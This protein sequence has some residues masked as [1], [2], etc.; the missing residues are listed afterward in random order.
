MSR[1]FIGC[2]ALLLLIYSAVSALANSETLA[3]AAGGLVARHETRIVVA[4]EV[5]LISSD[6]VLIDYD[7]R[8]D[9]NQDVTAEVAFPVPPYKNEAPQQLGSEQSFQGIQVWV[10]DKPQALKTEARATLGDDDVTQLLADDQVEIASFGRYER[11]QGG[12]DH[13]RD[14]ERLPDDEQDHLVRLGLFDNHEQPASALWTVHI[15]YYWQQRF[16]AHSTLHIRQQ[17]TPVVGQ[18]YMEGADQLFA[19]LLRAGQSPDELTVQQDNENLTTLAGFC[20]DRAWL[21]AAANRYGALKRNPRG[22]A[23]W[24]AAAFEPRWVDFLLTTGNSWRQP[25][26]DFTL[27]VERGKAGSADQDVTTSVSFCALPD[28]RIERLS[29]GRMRLHIDNFVPAGQLHIGFFDLPTG[30]LPAR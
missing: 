21:T 11:G 13:T 23:E 4:K 12:N 17:Y 6:R 2:A 8:N 1:R 16:P 30:T 27:I 14:W 5:L 19:S 18:G 10:E 29:D 7:F 3:I 24:E 20:P 22:R 26:E 25:I 9:T 15:E 28:T